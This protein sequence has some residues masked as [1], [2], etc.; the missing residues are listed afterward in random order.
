MFPG[1]ALK[2]QAWES[3]VPKDAIMKEVDDMMSRLEGA[4][5]R[6]R[7]RTPEDERSSKRQRRSRSR[8]PPPPPPR[9]RS[10]CPNREESS[11]GWRDDRRGRG[12]GWQLDERPV[13]YKIY[14]GRV[15]GLKEFGA[16][17]QLEGVAGRVEGV[18]TCVTF[19]HFMLSL[20]T[21]DRYGARLKHSARGSRE[22]GR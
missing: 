14:N 4:A 3:S 12:G 5:K 21:S 20:L 13:L 7:P 2:D 16:F 11:N 1:L 19:P 22:L 8:S 6:T 9:R 15:N 18:Y 10:P 17:V